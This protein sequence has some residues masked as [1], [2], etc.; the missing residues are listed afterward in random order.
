MELPVAIYVLINR[1]VYQY[2]QGVT[3]A[4]WASVEARA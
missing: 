2:C 4:A 1:C 3:G